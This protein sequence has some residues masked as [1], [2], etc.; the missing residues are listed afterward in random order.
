[1]I[2]YDTEEGYEEG[3]KVSSRAIMEA[4]AGNK[5]MSAASKD[6]IY[7]T[8]ETR[9]ISNIINAISVAMGINIE[10]QKEFIIN[11][12]LDSI[13]ETVESESDYKSKVREMAE[14]G[15]KIMSYKDFYNT[16]ILYYTLGSFLIY[17]NEKE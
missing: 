1:M 5:I 10:T 6:I 8:P 4:D 17:I 11:T 9:M 16:A 13:K 15:K 12:V 14:K 3:F 7:I 2:D